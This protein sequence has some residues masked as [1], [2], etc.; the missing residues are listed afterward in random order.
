MT[1][2]LEPLTFVSVATWP[3]VNARH[4]EAILPGAR[5]F[6]LAF[7]ARA[8]PVPVGFP[9]LPAP[10]VRAAI[11]EIE[12]PPSRRHWAAVV[13]SAVS[14]SVMMMTLLL[15]LVRLQ[16]QNDMVL[17]V[18]LMILSFGDPLGPG[19]ALATNVFPSPTKLTVIESE[20]VHA[21]AVA[22]PVRRMA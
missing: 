20:M 9:I 21:V 11:V 16:L 4:F 2:A 17:M 14:P 7:G 6:P 3:C 1:F 10:A 5:V 13:S 18:F 15:D 8:Y 12:A 22:R 19:A